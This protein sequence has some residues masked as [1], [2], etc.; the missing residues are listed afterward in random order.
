MFSGV[1][2]ADLKPSSSAAIGTVRIALEIASRRHRT[3]LPIQE[4]QLIRRFCRACIDQA[5]GLHL[6]VLKSPKLDCP[7][8]D[9]WI[10]VCSEP[11][12][13]SQYVRS[14]Y[15]LEDGFTPVLG[16]VCWR[17]RDGIRVYA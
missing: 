13:G 6:S 12:C 14:R 8:C 7:F 16:H 15:E 11:L 10:D 3:D 4:G 1:S 17:V 5:S 2:D 9:E